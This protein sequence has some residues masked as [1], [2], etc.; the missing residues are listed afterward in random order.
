MHYN[1]NM[2]G[3]I[4]RRNYLFI[5]LFI[6]IFIYIFIYLFIYLFELVV[7]LFKK[8]YQIS[9]VSHQSEGG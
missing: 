2:N 3:D 7:I 1:F 8:I 6:Y 5:Y 9:D 4:K